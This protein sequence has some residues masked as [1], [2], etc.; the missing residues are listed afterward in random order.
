MN[1]KS[2]FSPF[3]P[4]AWRLGAAMVLP[5]SLI[6]G[7]ASAAVTAPAQKPML[8]ASTGAKPNL[9]ITLDNSGS[10]ARPFHESYNVTSAAKAGLEVTR[11]CIA[12]DYYGENGQPGGTP[13]SSDGK[14]YCF[15]S[16]AS[17]PI[18]ECVDDDEYEDLTEDSK[19]SDL[20]VLS[21]WK[22][23][24]DDCKKNQGNASD[25]R[26]RKVSY[27]KNE[28]TQ[29]PANDG[30]DETGSA[31]NRVD[32]PWHA[33]R[34]VDVNPLYYNPRFTY[35]PR[36]NADGTPVALE[37]PVIQFV[38]N[39]DNNSSV[40]TK[41]MHDGRR[42][43]NWRDGSTFDGSSA[44]YSITDNYAFSYLKA[45]TAADSNTPAFTWVICPNVVSVSKRETSCEVKG[46]WVEEVKYDRTAP[47]KL[48]LDH[49]R[50]DCGANA[51]TCDI[52]NE[53]KNILNW[54][55]YYS[56]R[57]D[58]VATSIGISLANADY[59]ERLRVGYYNI[60]NDESVNGLYPAVDTGSL[61]RLRG[62]RI[63]SVSNNNALFAWLYNLGSNPAGG[64]PLHNSLARIADYY[65]VN[66]KDTT[67]AKE[68]PWA[69]DPSSREEATS[70]PELTCRRSFNLLFSD[71]AWSANNGKDGN[72]WTIS[73][74]GVSDGEFDYPATAVA[75]KVSTTGLTGFNGYKAE[76]YNDTLLGRKMYTPFGNDG[77]RKS[78]SDLTAKYYWHD[79]FR[80][81][82]NE[83]VARLGQPT[84]WQNVVTYTIGYLVRPSGDLPGATSGLSLTDI[85]QYKRDYLKSGS[86]AAKPIWA[87]WNST[88]TNA[89]SEQARIDDFIQAGFTGG[90]AG[91]SVT[92]PDDVRRSFDLILSDILNASGKDAG[93]AVAGTSSTTST[94][95]GRLKYSVGYKTID[96]SGELEAIRL[97]AAG[98]NKEIAWSANDKFPA[99]ASR[100]LFVFDGVSE[101]RTLNS[102][103]TL[104]DLPASLKTAINGDGSLP[105]NFISY[106]LG[107]DNTADINN[108]PFRQRASTLASSVNAPPLYVGA[109]LNMGYA[110]PAASAIPGASNYV[111][112][113]KD[114]FYTPGML[115]AATNQGFVHAF[116]AADGA[117]KIVGTDGI[118]IPPGTE[119]G[120]FMLKNTMPK[121]KNFA[122]PSY[123]FE[124]LADGP[125]VEQDVW[126]GTAWKQMVFGATGRGGKAV[127]GLNSPLN[128]KVGAVLANRIPTENDYRWEITRPDMGYI[129][130]T[131]AAGVTTLGQS[132]LLVNSGHYG[133]TAKAGLYVLDA[134]TGAELKFIELPLLPSHGI[135]LGGVTVVRNTQRQVVAAYAGDAMG[136]LWRFKLSGDPADWGVSNGAPLFTIPGNKPIYAAPAWQPH[137]G[138]SGD[139]CQAQDAGSC[140]TIVVVGTGILLDDTHLADTTAQALYGVWDNIGVGDADVPYKSSYT[141]V[142]QTIDAT[143]GKAGVGSG[144]GN[145][146]YKVSTN[147]LD[148]T[149]NR[150]WFIDLSKL[151]NTTGE[152]V[153]GDLFN[154]GGN[155]FATSVVINNTKTTEDSCVAGSGA[156]N[157]MYGVDALT[158]GLKRSFDQDGDGKADLYSVAFLPKGGFTRSSVVTK[159]NSN[160]PPE[161]Y[162]D[163]SFEG[164]VGDPKEGN[165]K[166]L[167]TAKATGDKGYN[168][169]VD[170]TVTIFDGKDSSGWRRSWRQIMNLPST[171]Y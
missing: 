7:G 2:F 105:D 72:A 13:K 132:V 141:M 99:L 146:Y 104:A 35:A 140:G 39:Q 46:M 31:Y 165:I 148:W 6:A 32:S 135:G 152:R 92:T 154:L 3:I 44:N 144:L 118:E 163:P 54:Y 87:T 125:M 8:T 107:D 96:N 1:T 19:I 26:K 109:R 116:N 27:N 5:L 82:N 71:G 126:D 76:G 139:A 37:S 20:T 29:Q 10:M 51:T 161:S 25:Y 136:N 129:T 128:P 22:K 63:S 158:G 68:N 112:F 86:A 50:T 36:V 66:S 164:G 81:I 130:N 133:P 134:V 117:E 145:T 67:A 53:I 15:K 38:S 30:V 17:T 58:A 40:Q 115:Y 90:G 147:A 9:M 64:T 121:L 77:K 168:T 95:D 47:V 73:G 84:T 108:N 122:N 60:N 113:L 91:Y 124:Y 11:V 16:T 155:V 103:S 85:E 78:L 70:N 48:P 170:G 65:Q 59:K 88:Q 21:Y 162:F 18:I 111:D 49:R 23:K 55:R 143:S 74:S 123:S 69:T 75:S 45:T 138:A 83:V 101:R 52:P 4:A 102:A 151:T 80:N 156:V 97:D 79:D 24:S 33:A 42:Y 62:V 159:S 41:T 166:L 28:L 120:A 100:K 12:P 94:L 43:Y 110:S 150:G 14:Y 93:V 89:P 167:P 61:D 153:I 157:V 171:L 56:Y 119:V 98:N 137:P 57:A 149:K 106:L 114:K 34:S 142:E 160:N 127:Y 169:G 131:I